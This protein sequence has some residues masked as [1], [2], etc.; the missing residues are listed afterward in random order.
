MSNYEFIKERIAKVSNL[1]IE[2]IERKIEAKKAKLSGLISKEGAAQIIAAELGI[3]FDDMDVKLSEIMSAMK[4]VNFHAKIINIFP[5]REFVR[6]DRKGKVVNLIIADETTNT[7]LV[8]WDTNHISLIEEGKIKLND[9]IEIKNGVVRDG[10]IHLNSASEIKKSDKVF[11][12]VKTEPDFDE[13]EIIDLKQGNSVKLRGTVVQ[14]FPPRFYSVCPECNKKAENS[15]DGFLCSEHGKIIPKERAILNFIL[16]D[17][18]ESIR[19]V[20]F[21][22]AIN[23]LIAEEELKDNEKASALR[24]D[25]LGTEV[26]VNGSVRKN[27]LF[28][29]MELIAFSV[30]KINVED[31]IKKFTIK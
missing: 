21:S 23:K 25:L 28:N 14:L 3:N 13:Q 7:R 31:L 24:D 12:D 15:T 22:D 26:F 16:D 8:L 29:N 4:K 2:E 27:N 5:V 6:N 17:G 10:E 18:T 9:V 19:T 11:K 30:E 20:M 1:D